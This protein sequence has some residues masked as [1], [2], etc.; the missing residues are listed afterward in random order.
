MM[1]CVFIQRLFKWHSYERVLIKV[2]SPLISTKPIHNPKL[3]MTLLV[4]N[5][6]DIIE[7]TCCSIGKWGW[8]GLL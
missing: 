3:M 5:E 1:K 2:L 4:R 6:A 7:L 8:M